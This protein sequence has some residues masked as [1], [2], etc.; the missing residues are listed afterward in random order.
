MGGTFDLG[1]RVV[2][3]TGGA[4]ILGSEMT[5]ALVENGA[6]VAVV[7]RNADAAEVVAGRFGNAAKAYIC[8]VADP[9]S[10]DRLKTLVEDDFGQVDV[11]I[12]NVATKTAN[13]FEPFETFP[14]DEWDEVIRTNLRSAIVSCQ[15][16]GT[17]MAQRGHGAIINTLSIYGILGPDQRIYEGSQY[18]GVAINTPEVYCTSKAG[19]LGLTNYLAAYWGH[20]GVRVN[21]I[22]P[23]GTQSG[24]N[25]TFV[26]RYSARV[27]LGRMALPT[28][29]AGAVCFLASDAAS[30]V[31][32][33]NLIVDGGLTVW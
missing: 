28:E 13:F 16:F 12:N 22:T 26:E 10:V 29:M 27:P 2:L 3:L 18:N 30:Y 31:N 9:D 20:R 19:L 24:Q 15:R 17:A 33:H 4:G 23:G 6:R 7:D 5:R 21:A 8:D 1:G 25:D 11:L 32:G 14:L